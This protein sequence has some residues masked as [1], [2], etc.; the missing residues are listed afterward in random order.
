MGHFDW[1]DKAVIISG[2][3]SGIGQALAENLAARGARLGL[4]GRDQTRLAQVAANARS[5]GS[6]A[7]AT[8]TADVRDAAAMRSA[9]AGLEQ[10][11]RLECE[12]DVAVYRRQIDRMRARVKELL[13][14]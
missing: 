5:A 14:D 10:Y 3:S 2:G 13:A 7:T 4:L 9:I 6:P 12:T 11:I 8:S 1:R